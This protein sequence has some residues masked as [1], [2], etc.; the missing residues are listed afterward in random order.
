MAP[1]WLV[2]EIQAPGP[3]I[4]TLHLAQAIISKLICNYLLPYCLNG[5]FLV[6]PKHSV[7]PSLLPFALPLLCFSQLL[8]PSKLPIQAHMHHLHPLWSPRSNLFQLLRLSSLASSKVWEESYPY[9]WTT[10]SSLANLTTSS[11]SLPRSHSIM[12]LMN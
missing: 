4:W 7:F 10:C 2:N 8:N 1:H 12:K 6:F 3:A 11:Q 5:H 9:C